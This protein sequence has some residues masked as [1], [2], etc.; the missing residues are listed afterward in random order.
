M[1]FENAAY[2]TFV[3][4]CRAAGIDVPIVPGLKVLTRKSLLKNIPRNFHVD[5]PDGL[6]G[7]ILAARDDAHIKEIGHAHALAQ[8]RGLLEGGAPG[9]HFFVYSDAPVTASVVKDLGL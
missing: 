4:R 8:A 1:F 2:F 9:V 7:E 5:I 3:E 6:V